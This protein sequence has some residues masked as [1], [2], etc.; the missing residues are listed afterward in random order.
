MGITV[1][2]FFTTFS[3]VD[4]EPDTRQPTA[5]AHWTPAECSNVSH[6]PV[7]GFS[8]LLCVSLYHKTKFLITETS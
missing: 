7:S 5:Q 6:E 2:L 4:A 1:F 8:P 3:K